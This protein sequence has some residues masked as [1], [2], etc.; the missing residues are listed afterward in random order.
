MYMNAGII[1]V[2]YPLTVFGYALLEEARPNRRYWEA[3]RAYTQGVLM[4]KFA[5]NLS[6]FDSVL[7]SDAFNSISAYVKIGIYEYKTL[8]DLT[9]Y[10]MPE[11]LIISF[12][13][14]NEIKLKLLGLYYENEMEVESIQEGIQR[15]IVKGDEE[16]M[17]ERK[18]KASNMCMNAYF[19]SRDDQQA[20]KNEMNQ[21]L[22]E[23]A[24]KEVAIEHERQ[25]FENLE[26]A[27]QKRYGE[28]TNEDNKAAGQGALISE[29]S[30]Y[31]QKTSRKFDLDSTRV[32]SQFD[33]LVSQNVVQKS[34]ET[35]NLK[36]Y[37]GM[38]K[39][40]QPEFMT[41]LQF[42][43]EN[44]EK[45]NWEQFSA[46]MYEEDFDEKFAEVDNR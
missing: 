26:D 25:E 35:D 38:R 5:L 12:I 7:Q 14:L 37:E 36:Y 23:D 13:M 20:R 1:S 44:Y 18:I 3:V 11:I 16:A 39:K 24:Q 17:E 45:E 2:F 27:I 29:I 10:M 42:K 8:K 46:G 40:S 31:I 30:S 4:F 15:N 34:L 6:I 19:E 9:L 21:L 32:N 28:K 41:A 22:M 43:E 33:D